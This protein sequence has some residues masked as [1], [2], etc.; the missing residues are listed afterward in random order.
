MGLGIRLHGLWQ[1]RWWVL[2]C[3]CLGLVAAEWSVAKISLTPPGLTSRALEMASASTQIV[4]D[5]PRSTLVDARQDTYGI[6]A[7]TNRAVLVGNVMASPPVRAAIAKKANIPVQVLQ[8]TPPL[9][10]KQPRVLAED[11]IE[12]HTSDIVKLNDQYRLFISANPTVP[13]LRIYAQAPDA[14]TAGLLANAAVDSMREHLAELA[15]G[16]DTP[17]GDQIKLMQLGRA[18]GVVINEGVQYRAAILAFLVTTGIACA[19]LIYLR[20]IRDGWRLAALADHA[21]PLN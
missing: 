7:L 12:R 21:A 2:G 4:V 6:D 17:G 8:I 15:D 9:T 13:V 1:M 19:T 3:V 20:R 14:P 10:P 18:H 11:G 16:S 5:T